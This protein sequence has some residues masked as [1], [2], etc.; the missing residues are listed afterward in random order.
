M[1]GDRRP[2]LFFDRDD[3]LMVNV[4]YL[5]DPKKVSAFPE[6]RE[7]LLKLQ[8]AGYLLFIVTNQSGVGRGLITLEQVHA[9]NATL[10]LQLGPEIVITQIYQ[11][12]ANPSDPESLLDRKPSPRLVHR[13]AE[14]HHLDLA[15]SHFIG[16]RLVDI[17]CG[18]NSGCASSLL[19]RHPLATGGH[20]PDENHR[21]EELATCIVTSL[22]H[23]AELIL[24]KTWS[25]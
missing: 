19:L 7:A 2:A 16:D 24:T 15:Q 21:A 23:A 10:L 20:E 14:E 18:L 4:P 3:T 5:G 6:A 17:Q 8:G 11:S 1:P 25:A 12:F 9:V 22:L 13:A